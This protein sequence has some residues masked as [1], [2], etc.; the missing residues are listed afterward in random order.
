M[1]NC[2]YFALN[3]IPFIPDE[4]HSATF[5]HS[6]TG[7]YIVDVKVDI[8][9]LFSWQGVF[10]LSASNIERMHIMSVLYCCY[11]FTLF[12][13]VCLFWGCYF[14]GIKEHPRTRK[15]LRKIRQVRLALFPL[16]LECSQNTDA[17]DLCIVLKEKHTKASQGW[18][19]P[20]KRTCNSRTPH[21]S[22]AQKKKHASGQVFLN[23]KT[24]IE[25]ADSGEALKL[26]LKWYNTQP[27]GMEENPFL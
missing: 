27:E 6:L 11:V 10:N 21:N 15:R 17:T 3:L 24:N 20:L 14:D 9:H 13:I 26:M 25:S 7:Q 16:K 8:Q 4:K 19:S 1:V 2:K 18:S 12:F 23:R 22:I 5:I